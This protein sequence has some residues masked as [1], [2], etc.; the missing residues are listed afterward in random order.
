MNRFGSIRNTSQNQQ[1]INRRRIIELLNNNIR[2]NISN[3]SISCNYN[4]MK[5]LVLIVITLIMSLSNIFYNNKYNDSSMI[6]QGPRF[7]LSLYENKMLRFS[8][9]YDERRRGKLRN[10]IEE[11]KF[12]T[13]ISDKERISLIINR[14]I[15]RKLLNDFHNY[16]FK[17]NWESIQYNNNSKIYNIGE[18]HFGEGFFNIK[19]K[20]EFFTGMEFFTLIMK[21]NEESYID[22]WIIHSSA[23]ILDN[24][25]INKNI[26]NN[27]FEIS[28][29]FDTTLFKGKYFNILNQENPEICKTKMNFSFPINDQVY[30]DN[31]SIEL[32]NQNDIDNDNFKINLNNFSIIMESSC[33]FKF[34]IIASI[35]EKEKEGKI[36]KNR[37][38]IYCLISIF[39]SIFYII[40]VSIVIFNMKRYEA[41]I[42]SMS[43]DCLSI[44]PIWNTYVG[45]ANINISTKFQELFNNISLIVII[46]GI[47][48]LLVDF[49]LLSIYWNIR[50][51]Q[52]D[53]SRYLK[54]RIRFYFIYY[55]FIFSSFFLINSFFINY[56]FIMILC[57]LLWVPQII[58]NI[59]N[60]IKYSYPFIYILSTTFDKL[61]Y[62]IYF[63]GVKNNFLMTKNNPALITI[64]V[65]FVVFTIIIMYIQILK[66]PRFMFP[67]SF[68][69]P[70]YDF[71]RTKEELISNNNNI[72]NE[73]CVICLLPIF[74]SENE[75]MIEMED[76]S[77]KN[78]E[79]NKKE[80]AEEKIDIVENKEDINLSYNDTYNSSDSHSVNSELERIEDNEINDQ[81]NSILSTEKIMNDEISNKNNIKIHFGNKT[82]IRLVE[83]EEI[84]ENKEENNLSYNPGF[85][86]NNY[87]KDLVFKKIKIFFED[88]LFIFNI[89]FNK[90]FFLFYK[91]PLCSEGK[92]YMLTPCNH[93][94]HSECLEKW[95]EYKKECPNCRKSME[96][97]LQ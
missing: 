53:A 76:K 14:N 58:F 96:G 69:H 21:N 80:S 16:N 74:S 37:I 57:I 2:I 54:E 13:I 23:S 46:S 90:N 40:S 12:D 89:L 10:L 59:R 84:E 42:S 92:P 11:D 32:K 48:F 95:L 1:D 93:V 67:G 61:F 36:I 39:S 70:L 85:S 52:I 25:F 33:G 63:R 77:K 81:N 18:T 9:P 31:H 50:R 56:F 51:T 3:Y 24:I 5:I 26:V 47:K 49:R 19:K 34:K 15:K 43:I 94:F 45:L 22:N 27:T 86:T 62:P 78:M 64:M 82:K 97:Y 87:Y 38:N 29:N 30:S 75:I 83:E 20:S 44:N 17:C 7:I 6:E 4:K 88:V 60:R 65:V 66:E 91:K 35:Y 73:E 72:G 41:V 55:L 79:E 8:L 28:G 71:F 68:N